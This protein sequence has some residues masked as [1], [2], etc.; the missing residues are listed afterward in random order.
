MVDPNSSSHSSPTS[1]RPQNQPEGEPNCDTFS[2]IVVLGGG[3]AGT[4]LLEALAG[5][6]VAADVT[7]IEPSPDHHDQPAWMR[8]GTEGVEKERTRSPRSKEI[9][10][11]VTWIQSLVTA[12]DPGAQTVDTEDG[13]TVCYDYLVVAL[14]IKPL[15]D[16]IL[17]LESSL[18][19]RGICS[20]YGYEQAGQAWEMIRAFE[21]G[22][23]IFTAP[24]TPHKG[25]SAPLQI[26]RR[27]ESLW[28]D[29]GVRNRTELFF[30]VTA[31]TG[32]EEKTY[33]K[34]SREGGDEDLHVYTGYDLIKVRPEAREAIFSVRKGQSQSRQVLPYELL[35]VVP[36]MRPPALLEESGL[37]HQE[38]PM[39]AYMEV[40]PETFRHKR[41]GSVF[42]IGDVIGV[43]G[44]K[45]G[46]QAR[47]Q[48][49]AV[50]QTLERIVHENG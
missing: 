30:T 1:S 3:E 42:G 15:W 40:H 24:S 12:I 35:H 38:G 45:T 4:A 20:V 48:G 33:E 8:V 5:R 32:I 49:R 14:G 13:T 34:L 50:A 17:G 10:P 21:G 23:A 9:P 16:R 31:P 36:P 46:E 6:G 7:L 44:I 41:F 47:E 39:K 26:L 18:G 28:R 29:T 43:E 27:A 19:S 25:G 2:P 37:A 11:P 22:R